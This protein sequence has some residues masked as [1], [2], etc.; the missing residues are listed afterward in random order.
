M[1]GNIPIATGRPINKLTIAKFKSK[2]V[3]IFGYCKDLLIIP[4]FIKRIVYRAGYAN[5]ELD[6]IILEKAVSFTAF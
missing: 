3:L 5:V 4:I 1:C 6:K 2:M